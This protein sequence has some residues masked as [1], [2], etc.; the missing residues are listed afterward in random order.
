MF[1]VHLIGPLVPF[2][3]PRRGQSLQMRAVIRVRTGEAIGRIRATHL[4][5]LRFKNLPVD[6][7][8]LL[9]K[10]PHPPIPLRHLLC[11][12]HD[13]FPHIQRYRL[14][15]H[16]RGKTVAGHGRGLG[17]RPDKEGIE[18]RSDIL[19][20]PI[21]LLLKHIDSLHTILL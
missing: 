14:S 4:V 15:L 2:K 12:L 7:R 8:E 20:E 18:V 1:V 9:Q 17:D 5:F 6:L 13:P 21:P 10:K 19:P 11:F 16:L 3:N